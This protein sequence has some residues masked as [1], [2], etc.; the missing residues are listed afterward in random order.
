VLC[1]TASIGLKLNAS[2]M[3]AIADPMSLPISASTCLC[4]QNHF[5][6]AWPRGQL[7]LRS[8]LGFYFARFF[9]AR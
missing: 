6:K 3:I 1:A 8:Q 5:E 4:R 9:E 2:A 7:L